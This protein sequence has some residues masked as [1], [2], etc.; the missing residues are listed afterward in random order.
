MSGVTQGIDTAPA[1]GQ[2]PSQKAPAVTRAGTVPA[3]ES[4]YT[5][6]SHKLAEMLTSCGTMHTMMR[7]TGFYA[8]SIKITVTVGRNVGGLLALR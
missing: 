8:D 4:R 6:R 7:T 2:E 3:K 1:V 5:L